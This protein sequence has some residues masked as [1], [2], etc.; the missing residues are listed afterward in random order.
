MDGW[1]VGGWMSWRDNTDVEL[2][3]VVD[4]LGGSG[5]TTLAWRTRM[6]GLGGDR[7][8]WVEGCPVS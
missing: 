4:R 7:I 1:V 6:D 5:L 8:S 3:C 2:C